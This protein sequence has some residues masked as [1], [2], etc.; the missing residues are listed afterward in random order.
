MKES[1]V[2][3]LDDED[4]ATRKDAALCCGRLVASSFSDVASTQFGAT[5]SNRTGGKRRRL[6]EEV[7]SCNCC[8]SI[9]FYQFIWGLHAC[10]LCT[11]W[12]K[13]GRL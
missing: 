6:I 3:Y 7:I 11:L 1:V 10:N 13:K 2:G 4:G 12:V 9:F 5:R 8:V